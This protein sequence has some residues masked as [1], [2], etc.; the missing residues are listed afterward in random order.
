M[1]TVSPHTQVWLCC[2]IWRSLCCVRQLP[3]ERLATGHISY[4]HTE[5]SYFITDG[6][7][8]IPCSL[9]FDSHCI[10]YCNQKPINVT[11]KPFKHI[12]ETRSGIH[13]CSLHRLG[14]TCLCTMATSLVV[15]LISSLSFISRNR[16]QQNCPC[17]FI[18]VVSGRYLPSF[19]SH[20]PLSKW[21]EFQWT[22]A[23]KVP[24]SFLFSWI[25]VLST[26]V[27]FCIFYV[28]LIWKKK[29]FTCQ[30][31]S[32]LP[33]IHIYHAHPFSSVFHQLMNG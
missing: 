2:L 13:R 26:F 10:W 21:I 20:S 7:D 18:P 17:F 32:W 5:W 31:W 19:F 1:F 27:L 15:R 16:T 6:F 12:L 3:W 25:L 4:L 33:N 22:Y 8:F 28:F 11:L 30:S 14:R 29:Y 9:F 23:S 24:P